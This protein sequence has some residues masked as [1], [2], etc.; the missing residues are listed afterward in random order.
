MKRAGVVWLAVFALLLLYEVYAVF[1]STPG[2]TLSEAVWRYGHHP[3]I[4]FC[5]GVLMGHFFWQRSGERK[6]E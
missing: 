6:K 1:N 4:P 2:D 5:V 3:M